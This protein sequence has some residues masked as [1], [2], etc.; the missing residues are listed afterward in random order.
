MSATHAAVYISFGRGR[1]VEGG[2]ICLQNMDPDMTVSDRCVCAATRS[3]QV[4]TGAE[5]Q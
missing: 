4:A 2:L 5:T 1:W 3:E